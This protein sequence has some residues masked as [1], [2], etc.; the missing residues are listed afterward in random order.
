M[1]G[2]EQAGSL[3]VPA[4]VTDVGGEHAAGNGGHSARHQA[5]EFAAGHF[6]DVRLDQQGRFRLA[7]KDV[8]GRGQ[9]FRTGD[10]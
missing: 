4:E 6:T 8:A 3:A 9:T 5:E 10:F 7:Q 1:F 2:E